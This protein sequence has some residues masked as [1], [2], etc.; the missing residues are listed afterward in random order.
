M[1]SNHC[2][3]FSQLQ[4]RDKLLRD[5]GFEYEP[6]DEELMQYLFDTNDKIEKLAQSLGRSFQSDARGRISVVHA[7]CMCDRYGKA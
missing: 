7:D 2:P 3:Y 4:Q 5:H 1:Q 6:T